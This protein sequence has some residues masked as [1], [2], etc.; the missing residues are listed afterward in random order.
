MG[1]QLFMPTPKCNELNWWCRCSC[2]RNNNGGGDGEWGQGSLWS[3]CT[4][5]S[6]QGRCVCLL[7]HI[8]NQSHIDESDKSCSVM[9]ETSHTCFLLWGHT[10]SLQRGS[11]CCK[12]SVNS[13]LI[14]TLVNTHGAFRCTVELTIYN[15]KVMDTTCRISLHYQTAS[16]PQELWAGSPHV[17]LSCCCWELTA[18]HNMNV[19]HTGTHEL[20]TPCYTARRLCVFTFHWSV[21]SACQHS[22]WFMN[23]SALSDLLFQHFSSLY[24]RDAVCVLWW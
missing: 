2:R 1:E 11:Y 20:L 19:C 14:Y 6:L 15:P 3:D 13:L 21:R 4:I 16:S 22:S 23:S 24:C 5:Q 7:Y 12:Q 8:S 17:P 9:E 18:V 10:I